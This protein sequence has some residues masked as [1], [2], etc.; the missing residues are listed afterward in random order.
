MTK[1]KNNKTKPKEQTSKVYPINIKVGKYQ[2]ALGLYRKH[3]SLP[4]FFFLLE[5]ATNIGIGFQSI[6]PELIHLIDIDDDQYFGMHGS[7]YFSRNNIDLE[8][9]YLYRQPEADTLSIC[10]A[11]WKFLEKIGTEQVW[12]FDRY[13]V[14]IND[15]T[16][17]FDKN[18]TDNADDSDDV[19]LKT[20]DSKEE[21]FFSDRFRTLLVESLVAQERSQK[22]LFEL[23]NEHGSLMVPWAAWIA[24]Y[25]PTR[26]NLSEGIQDLSKYL[27]SY[28]VEAGDSDF[29]ETEFRN[30]PIRIDRANA[31]SLARIA[32]FL[33]F[34]RL[35]KKVIYKDLDFN[36]ENFFSERIEHLSTRD[37]VGNETLQAEYIIAISNLLMVTAKLDIN[38]VEDGIVAEH[39]L[40][41]DFLSDIDSEYLDLACLAPLPV[42]GFAQILGAINPF[43]GDRSEN[44]H[45]SK[46]IRV[47][48]YGLA[49]PFDIDLFDKMFTEAFNGIDKGVELNIRPL[50]KRAAKGWL[51]PFQH[52]KNIPY[53][54]DDFWSDEKI[55][56]KISESLFENDNHESKQCKFIS[57]EL[58]EVMLPSSSISRDYHPALFTRTFSN[59]VDFIDFKGNQWIEFCWSLL[60]AGQIRHASTALA[61]NI[62]IVSV[63][64]FYN[65][66]L[67]KNIDIPA[68]MQLSN[69]LSSYS[70]FDMVRQAI[71]DLFETYENLP[72]VYIGSL[73]EFLPLV[74]A[75]VISIKKKT[76][77][78]FEQYKNS[79]L[80]AGFNVT[81]LSDEARE[82]L[83]K[84]Y[85][86]ARIKDFQAFNLSGDAVRNYVL[87]VEGELRSRAPNIDEELAQE[88][89][90]MGVEIDWRPRNN[91]S[92]RRGVFRGLVSISRTVEAFSK[93]S[94]AAKEKLAGFQLLA[95][96]NEATLFRTSMREFGN[97]RNDVQHADGSG[98]DAGANLARVEELMFGNGGL[99]RILCETR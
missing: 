39:E 63:N 40:L 55:I 29:T 51:I 3:P 59:K 35:F 17:L 74:N 1:N 15:Y 86:L 81:I 92:G 37:N 6:E 42:S 19:S 22:A 2:E 24:D 65:I 83:L 47:A 64:R 69:R 80:S 43:E 26:V 46:A 33:I 41:R 70:S 25:L 72:S 91:G 30:N 97:I 23:A 11:L 79:L 48:N 49:S 98:K 38:C 89:K 67:E 14:G 57:K 12:G 94:D 56:E 84:G 8:E 10:S 85:T 78:D 5:H 21:G 34:S 90:Y 4:T 76:E 99:V 28:Y 75:T 58:E 61:L 54:Y 9:V 82:N 77:H 73:K 66:D 52:T 44:Y 36:L 96:H 16:F 53:L 62:T 93:L 20:K 50:I 95:M 13:L 60:N 87:A 27:A 31:K 7:R 88:L 71:A 32:E 68:I 45:V 18:L